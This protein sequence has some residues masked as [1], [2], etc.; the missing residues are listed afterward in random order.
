MPGNPFPSL[1]HDHGH[2]IA[3]A[4][5]SAAGLCAERGTRLTEIR[6]RVLELVWS[7]HEPVGAYHLLDALRNKGFNV[8]PPTVYRAL[9]FLLAQGFIHRIEHLNAY[10]GC[11]H[12]ERPH[13]GLFL[14][15]THCH[16]AVEIDDPVFGSTVERSAAAADFIV[17][18]TM[19]EVDGLCA[20]CQETVGP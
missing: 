19:I 1:H 3:S 10:V 7:N 16:T 15:C 11:S 12:P 18:R 13:V 14:V 4:L 9:E 20:R 17:R 5:T 8:K 6:S 2:C